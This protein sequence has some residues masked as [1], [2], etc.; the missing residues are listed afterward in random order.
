MHNVVDTDIVF[1]TATLDNQH[2]WKRQY[3]A[4]T[5]QF[6]PPLQTRGVT[7]TRRIL[8]CLV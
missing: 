7:T 4:S 6:S 3:V 1:F 2:F 8:E 5:T